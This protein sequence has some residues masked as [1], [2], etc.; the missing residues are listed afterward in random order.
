MSDWTEAERAKIRLYLGFPALWHQ[1]EP[2]LENALDTVRAIADGGQQ[3]DAATVTLIRAAMIELA[4]IDS[5]LSNLR[6]SVAILSA[7]TDK[8]TMDAGRGMA[9]L[10]QEGRRLITQ[11]AIPLGTQ[12]IRDYYTGLPLR[13][14]NDNPFGFFD[15]G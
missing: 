8:V 14:V 12:P 4:S 2:R 15:L 7:G 3:P 1:R 9:I 10:K 13:D 11:L 5:H 6:C